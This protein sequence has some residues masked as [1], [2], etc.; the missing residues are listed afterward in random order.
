M[1]RVVS[2][3]ICKFPGSEVILQTSMRTEH[4]DLDLDQKQ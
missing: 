1:Y 2:L 4:R 3:F